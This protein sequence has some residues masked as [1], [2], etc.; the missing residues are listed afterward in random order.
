ML[1]C[2]LISWCWSYLHTP[3]LSDSDGTQC[4]LSPLRVQERNTSADRRRL[5]EIGCSCYCA[6]SSWSCVFADVLYATDGER[7]VTQGL[8][9]R[10]AQLRSCLW[11][12]SQVRSWSDESGTGR[13][14]NK[15]KG[16]EQKTLP[17][18]SRYSFIHCLFQ[19]QLVVILWM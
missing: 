12:S 15:D 9:Y 7:D 8:V 4:S 18:Y 1:V 6:S 5:F 17:V 16:I 14:T 19:V 11:H 13:K 2:M 10:E 3:L